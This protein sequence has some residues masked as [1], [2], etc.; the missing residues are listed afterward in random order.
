[1][2]AAIV[3]GQASIEPSGVPVVSL[4]DRV[5]MDAALADARNALA[6]ALADLASRASALVGARG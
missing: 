5:G 6:D 4:A 1:M 2:S 3:S